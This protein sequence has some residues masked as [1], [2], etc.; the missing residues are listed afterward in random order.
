MPQGKNS[1]RWKPRIKQQEAFDKVRKNPIGKHLFV[2]PGGYGKTKAAIGAYAEAREIGSVNRLL[3]VA[4]SREQRDAWL[5]CLED[6]NQMNIPVR[7]FSVGDG[8]GH[9]Y[10]FAATDIGGC[11]WAYQRHRKNE[12]EVFVVTIQ[13][14]C[15][16]GGKSSTNALME[17]GRWMVIAEEAHHYADEKQWGNALNDLNYE[18]MV[19]LSATPFRQSGTHIF[20]GIME[21][22]SRVVE[23]SIADA[24]AEGAIRP[25]KVEKA[26]YQVEFQTSDK[27]QTYAFK[28]E[29]LRTFL[30]ENNL[31]LSEFEARQDLRVLDQFVKPIFL[32]ALDKLDE[33]NDIH[34]RQHQMIVHAPSVLTAKT[35]C[36]WINLL[37]NNIDGIAARWVGT[38]ADQSDKENRKVIADF[39][40]NKFPILVQVQMFGE[41]SDN[42][43]ASVGLWLS[44][45]GSDNASSWQGMVRHS[46]RNYAIPQNQDVA[47]LFIPEDSPALKRAIELSTAS[48]DF[49]ESNPISDAE[50]SQG[51]IKQLNIPGLEEMERR[52]KATAADLIDISNTEEYKR[53]KEE[54]EQLLQ[55]EKN[56]LLTEGRREGMTEAQ[57]ELVMKRLITEKFESMLLKSLESVNEK[58]TE[59]QIREEWSYRVESTVKKIV[60]NVARRFHPQSVEKST[61]ITLDRTILGHLKKKINGHLKQSSGGKGRK[62][63][64]VS[65]LKRQYDY[66]AKLAAQI[67]KGDIPTWLVM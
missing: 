36:N 32:A 3:I 57:A 16:V 63:L 46:R 25:I 4:P 23:C 42:I 48:G 52:I 67:D 28:L 54:M 12:C 5:E 1:K 37:T 56:V 22:N 39:K 2:L 24:I 66:L 31:E 43:R 7:S 45:L 20:S 8:S 10:Q 35:Y 34:P 38:G 60:R 49:W 29:E 64:D 9:S 14:L 17:T 21:D 65:D 18:L 61:I 51:E 53:K 30:Y 62:Q 47:Y 13:S 11:S 41:G 33:L 27:K 40:A 26:A 58:L 6:F 55:R 59:N 44:L 15:S 19:G 50:F